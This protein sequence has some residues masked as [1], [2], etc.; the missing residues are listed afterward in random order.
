[1]EGQCSLE[2]PIFFFLKFFFWFSLYN[3]YIDSSKL[4]RFSQNRAER[5]LLDEVISKMLV[6][7]IDYALHVLMR[8]PSCHFVL[9]WSLCG[10][11]LV[12]VDSYLPFSWLVQRSL[13]WLI[14]DQ[15][16]K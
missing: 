6:L 10:L 12:A 15:K 1:M 14:D 3:L 5:I 2:W 13:L 16:S 8:S 9:A 11:I 7:I 4:F